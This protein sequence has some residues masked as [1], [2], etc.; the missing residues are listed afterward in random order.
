MAS[1]NLTCLGEHR[2]AGVEILPQHVR[3]K[4]D[5]A[6][7]VLFLAEAVQIRGE[8]DLRL[9]F[10]LAIAVIV[11]GDDRDH[12][13]ALVAA[14]HLERAAAVVDFA[15]IAPAHAVA[16][17]ALGGVFVVRQAQSFF[18]MPDE[19]RRQNH[20]AGVAGPVHHVERGIV[21][22]QIRIAA[23]AENAFHE[24]QI[25]DQA[26]RREETRSPCSSRDRFRLPGKP[27]AAAAAT[28]TAA[29]VPPGRR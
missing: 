16:P 26:G 5:R 3:G 23:V 21:F 7:G 20:A 27:A 18:L 17:L 25:A 19:M 4:R 2:A 22:R 1:S 29:P 24:I 8:A 6:A 11:V 14:R 10:L 9:H 12:H 15:G 28:Q 13:A